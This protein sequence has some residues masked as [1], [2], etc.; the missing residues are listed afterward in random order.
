MQK[1][2][3]EKKAIFGDAAKKWF[4]ANY[5]NKPVTSD[6]DF[7]KALEN[8][9]IKYTKGPYQGMSAAATNAHM[10]AQQ[11][12][13]FKYIGDMLGYGAAGGIGVGLAQQVPKL[14]A[15]KKD[16]DA[17][18][19][20]ELPDVTPRGKSRFAKLLESMGVTKSSAWTLDDIKAYVASAGAKAGDIAA[21]SP[22]ILSD[23]G[24][25]L[26]NVFTRERTLP[27]P[28]ETGLGGLPG[29]WAVPAYL[30]GG[31]G[32]FYGGDKLVDWVTDKARSKMLSDRKKKLQDEFEDLLAE[33]VNKSAAAKG[34]DAVADAYVKAA[35]G[36][37]SGTLATL[38][39]IIA[40][41]AFAGGYGLS[42]KYDALAGKKKALELLL[43]KRKLASPVGVPLI[44]G[45][46]IS[47]ESTESE[48]EDP[49]LSLA[50]LGH[51][52]K[53]GPLDWWQQS[54]KP[55]AK[56]VLERFSAPRC[57]WQPS[58]S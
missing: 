6:P 40:A 36:P 21:K 52:K 29:G 23:T 51:V 16:I 50:K 48:D 44:P 47:T 57:R 41:G 34:L 28:W 5:G 46:T 58:Q 49:A 18:A 56:Y 15:A 24:K 27:T 53:A 3:V 43:K 55:F 32:A 42:T 1:S 14:L 39:A 35:G 20:E 22:N 7:V 12:Q 54:G 19:G 17:A 9:A 26:K 13:A 33:G 11:A 10:R 4:L 37:V 38:A 25:A 45:E 30:L 8:A 31:A 2:S